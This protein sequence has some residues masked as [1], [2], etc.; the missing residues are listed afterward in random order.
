MLYEEIQPQNQT[1]VQLDEVKMSTKVFDDFIDSEAADGI[2][3]GFEAELIFRGIAETGGGDYYDDPE[4]DESEDRRPRSIDDIVEFFHDGDHNSRRDAESLR[5][6]LQEEFWEWQSEQMNEAWAEA[7]AEAVK[8]YIVDND[9][10]EE[11]VMREYMEIEMELTDEAIDEAMAWY[12]ERSRGITSSKQQNE[13]KRTDQSYTNFIEAADAIDEQ[14]EEAVQESI[15]SGDRNYERAREMW[16]DDVRDDYDEG[17]WLRDS[18]YSYMT[19]VYRNHDINWPY[20]TYSDPEPEGGYSEASA[21]RL[22]DTMEDALDVKIKVA[23]GYHSAARKPGLWIFEP[24]SSLEPDDSEDM[25]VEIISPP[26]PLKET[27]EILPVFYAWANSEGAYSNDSTGFHIGVSLP[28]DGG[29]VDYI[30][31]AL[32]LGDQYVLD[33]FER[34]SNYFAK[35][36]MTKL[37]HDIETGAIKEGD[38]ENSMKLMRHNLIGLAN[39]TLKMSKG[40]DE[41][42]GHGKYTSI[43]M[44]GDYIEFRSMGS[45]SYFSKPDSLKKVLDTVKRYAYAMYIASKPELF[46][47]EYAKKLYK[48]LDKS[49][50]NNDA[51]MKEFADYVASIGG[52]T[53]PQTLKDFFYNMKSDKYKDAPLP[54]RT[55]PIRTGRRDGQPDMYWWKVEAGKLNV[56]VQAR[57]KEE[58]KHEAGKKWGVAPQLAGDWKITHI[59]DPIILGRLNNRPTIDLDL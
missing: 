5:E 8:E 58:A 33:Q 18:E 15:D 54:D 49:G 14:L 11:Q 7:E 56:E 59:T 4:M 43:N 46:R 42:F 9:W 55:T 39:K 52:A 35:S 13:L 57:N 38:I 2:L 51:A 26:M 36:A 28:N 10:D 27:L 29:H 32:F 20:W 30:K 40:R 6:T 22:A 3:A 12:G 53:D 48:L 16:E 50:S 17:D 25:P 31:L 34:G 23:S 21:Q 45:E 24:D 41:G 44:K 1:P 37:R 47:D 19:D